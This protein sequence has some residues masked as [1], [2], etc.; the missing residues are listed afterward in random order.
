M[1][2]LE[3]RLSIGRRQTIVPY[4]SNVEPLSVASD[5]EIQASADRTDEALDDIFERFFCDRLRA[6]FFDDVAQAQL[7]AG[8]C[9]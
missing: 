6:D 1:E 4:N 3:R 9:Q 5:G 8:V 7:P 2:R